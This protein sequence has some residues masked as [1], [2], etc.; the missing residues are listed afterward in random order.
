MCADVL[1]ENCFLAESFPALRTDE[2][3]LTAVNSEMLVQ[4]GSL[5]ERSVAIY[6]RKRFFV[7]VN[8]NVLREMTLLPE[9]FPTVR[10]TVGPRIRVY[11]LVLEQR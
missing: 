3:L 1:I 9:T 5:P 6:A 11:S 10:T 2:W 7:R 8:P 4:Y